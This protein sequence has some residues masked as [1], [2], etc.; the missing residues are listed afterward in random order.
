MGL[1][2]VGSLRITLPLTL[3]MSSEMDV[4]T[5]AGSL[6]APLVNRPAP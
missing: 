1:V 2:V 5:L 6:D 3:R 4:I